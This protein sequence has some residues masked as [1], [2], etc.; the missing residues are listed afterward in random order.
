M[1]GMFVRR[2]RRALLLSVAAVLGGA[3]PAVAA[4]ITYS[5]DASTLI[6]SGGDAANHQIQFRLSADQ[7]HDEI[8]DT[9]PFT[10][11]PGDCTVI[12]A[13]TWISCPAHTNVQ[14]DLGAGDDD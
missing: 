1:H 12:V 10:I 5:G 7:A 13:N 11:W 9:V 3:V 2:A 14:V 4:S 6:V 8:L